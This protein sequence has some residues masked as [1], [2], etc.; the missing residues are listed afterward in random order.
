MNRNQMIKCIF[1]GDRD[2][3]RDYICRTGKK[4][5]YQYRRFNN[6][7]VENITDGNIVLSN[8][9]DF[10]DPYDL[11][12]TLDWNELMFTSNRV[13][14]FRRKQALKN[15]VIQEECN[16]ILQETREDIEKI[17]IQEKQD[18][19][20]SCFS[21]V[22]TSILMWGHY[23]DCHRGYCAE[24]NVEDILSL[25]EE[26]NI[27][28]FD[29]DYSKEMVK[30]GV[31]GDKKQQFISAFFVKYIDWQYEHEWR[32]FKIDVNKLDV[33]ECANS[34][35]GKIIY[36]GIKPSRIILG[37]NML[38]QNKEKIK[39]ICQENNIGLAYAYKDLYE[40]KLN[41]RE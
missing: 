38:E 17:I 33:E 4:K 10:N 15:K 1:D 20:I 9:L 11:Y 31:S 18:V 24:Y 13:E 39:N 7:A 16:R 41:I 29:V 36:K 19:F 6:Y 30:I 21:T 23:A 40:Y 32:L 3:M 2:K 12:Y 34:D 8:P 25:C 28:F 5:I 14:R 37:T 26:K 27:I 22:P 35:Y